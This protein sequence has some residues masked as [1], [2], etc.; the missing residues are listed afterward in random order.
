MLMRRFLCLYQGSTRPSTPCAYAT[1]SL[2]IPKED[3]PFNI[4]LFPN[5]RATH[6]HQRSKDHPSVCVESGTLL[7]AKCYPED[8]SGV[9][10]HKKRCRN[11]LTASLTCS[12][13]SVLSWGR[14]Q[15]CLMPLQGSASIQGGRTSGDQCRLII[16][17]DSDTSQSIHS[18]AV[19]F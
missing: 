15:V 2:L 13:S 1:V 10:P 7:P 9:P 14:L 3:L 6:P 19:M 4:P 18:K 12:F 8:A 5:S 16:D 11:F 17:A